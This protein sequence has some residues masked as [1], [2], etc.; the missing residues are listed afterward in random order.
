[1]ATT[2]KKF[3]GN[4]DVKETQYGEI[5][6]IGFTAE[7]LDMLREHLA[8]GWVN[9]DILSSQKG[10]KY[11]VINDFKADPSKGTGGQKKQSVPKQAQQP[12]ANGGD[13]SDDLPF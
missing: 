1:M 4:V 11:A 7:H 8:G 12:I 6:K 9:V 5:I 3:V 10:G 13:D 2:D